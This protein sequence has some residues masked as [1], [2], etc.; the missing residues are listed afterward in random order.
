MKDI[1]AHNGIEQAVHEV[2]YEG[3]SVNESA[4]CNCTAY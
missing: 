4:D 1:V 2:K 3:D